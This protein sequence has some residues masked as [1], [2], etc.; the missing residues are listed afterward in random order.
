MLEGFRTY[1]VDKNQPEIVKAFRQLGYGVAHTHQA[2]AGFPDIVIGKHGINVLVEIKDGDEVPSA[3]MLN[4]KQ[5][6][7]HFCWPGLR[8]VITSTEDVMVFDVN[9]REL[10][11]KLNAAGIVLRV[12]G[13][14]DPIYREALV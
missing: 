4:P 11:G 12:R 1:R 10:V 13:C 2:G 6:K 8:C 9:F 14:Q 5:R 3:R 7:F